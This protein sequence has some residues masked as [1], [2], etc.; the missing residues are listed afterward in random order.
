[1]PAA[2]FSFEG[3]INRAKLWL[4]LL[5]LWILGAIGLAVDA[6]T[7]SRFPGP[8]YWIAWVV[9]IVPWL[10]L[11]VKRCH[12]RG[13]S[14]W[15]VL[16]ALIPFANI[17]YLIEIGFLKG[18][19]GSNRYGADPLQ[20]PGAVTSAAPKAPQMAGSRQPGFVTCSGARFPLP[21]VAGTAPRTR[22][23]HRPDGGLLWVEG[24]WRGKL[25]Y[26]P[27]GAYYS[28]PDRGATGVSGSFESDAYSGS[29]RLEDY[30]S[31]VYEGYKHRYNL[32]ATVT[33][34][35]QETRARL[36]YFVDDDLAD[37]ERMC[38]SWEAA[39]VAIGCKLRPRNVVRQLRK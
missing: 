15:F 29:N 13:H 30:E 2:L 23:E 39:L 5:L 3:R 1:M 11:N 18:T 4:G 17:W 32:T 22:S 38:T 9:S 7:G 14:G 27:I 20:L 8:G 35:E 31:T 33:N 21:L 19:T 37:F 24:S 12:D 26:Q 28:G 25:R 16:V 36:V 6:A 34:R 10:A